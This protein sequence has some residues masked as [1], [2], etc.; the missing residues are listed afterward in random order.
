MIL[1]PKLYKIVSNNRSFKDHTGRPALMSWESVGF[2]R[3]LPPLASWVFYM[4]HPDMPRDFNGC[5][6]SSGL[7]DGYSLGRGGSF[8]YEFFFLPGATAEE[9][10]THFRGGDGGSRYHLALD[11]QGQESHKGQEARQRRRSRE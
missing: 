5:A 9:C 10:Y 3:S 7:N 1:P 6:F 11:P 4:I 8:R 2:T